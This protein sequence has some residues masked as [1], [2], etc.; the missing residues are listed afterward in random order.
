[1]KKRPKSSVNWE[2][3]YD[4]QVR[5]ADLVSSLNMTWIDNSSIY[6][7]RSKNSQARAYARIW[8]L[9]QIWQ[10]ALSQKPSYC[11]EV[12]SE[13]FDSL[14]EDK[15]DEVLLHELCH[16]PKN[17]SGSLLPHI[18]KRGSRNFHDRVHELVTLYKNKKR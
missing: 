18:R 10:Q 14:T 15:Q 5:I 16:I 3:A 9:G 17:F 7:F 1:M 4:I 8:G 12:L 11:I 6:C 13:K 2:R